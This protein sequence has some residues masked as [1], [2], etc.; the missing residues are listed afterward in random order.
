MVDVV[1]ASDE[2]AIRAGGQKAGIKL[3]RLLNQLLEDAVAPIPMTRDER[4]TLIRRWCGYNGNLSST[5]DLYAITA[6]TI[7]DEIP[8]RKPEIRKILREIITDEIGEI[9]KD[10]S[11]F[12]TCRFHSFGVMTERDKLVEWVEVL[13]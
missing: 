10:G 4:L 12:S 2:R 3:V 7:V 9:T 1:I 8:G 5:K 6:R 13:L 11:G